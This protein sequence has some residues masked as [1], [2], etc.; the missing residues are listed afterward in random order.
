[1]QSRNKREGQFI[2]KFHKRITR[3]RYSEKVYKF[4][5]SWNTWERSTRQRHRKYVTPMLFSL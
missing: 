2:G 5:L 1:M 3:G 4:R